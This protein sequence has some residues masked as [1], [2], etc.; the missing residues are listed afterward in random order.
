VNKIKEFTICL[1]NGTSKEVVGKQ[2]NLLDSLSDKYKIHWNNRI[3]RHPGPY[4]SYSELLNDAIVTSK[5]EWL[6]MMN[7]RVIPTVEDVESILYNLENGFAC[8]TRYSVGFMG[9]S[10][11]LIRNIGFFDERFYGG[12]YEDDDFVLR[13]RLNDLAYYE[14]EEAEYDQSW[15]STLFPSDGALCS[16][17]EPWFYTKWNINPNTIIK[18]VEEESYKKYDGLLGSSVEEIKN[19][20]KG[21]KDSKIGIMFKERAITHRGGPSRT[22]HFRKDDVEFRK[23][24]SNV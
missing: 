9:F 5:T 19:S 2:M 21:W 17:S 13:L 22:H 20:W 23:I 8:S 10:K 4:N 3:D 11:E 14:S 7:D 16:K 12:G 1:H 6:I 18:M 24:I 15:K